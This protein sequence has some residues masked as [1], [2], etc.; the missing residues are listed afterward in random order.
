MF[1][2]FIDLYTSRIYTSFVELMDGGLQFM[3]TSADWQGAMY[4]TF[5]HL[6]SLITCY[7]TVSSVFVWSFQNKSMGS[8]IGASLMKSGIQG[9][10]RFFWDLRNLPGRWV[11]F[12]YVHAGRNDV[13]SPLLGCQKKSGPGDFAP[14]KQ[15]D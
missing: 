1:G 15:I 5:G 6:I 10:S 3:I 14:T 9:L 7:T 11:R 4:R 8:M 12:R 13:R 2:L